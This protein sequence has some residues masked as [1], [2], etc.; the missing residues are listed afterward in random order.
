MHPALS[1]IFFTTLSGLGYGLLA[2]SGVAALVGTSPR[3][4]LCTLAL[5]VV[6]SI[7]G[8]LC[9]VGHLG[10]P[11]RAWRAFSQWRTS[12]LSR[13]GIVS[14]ATLLPALVLI[15]AL[16]ARFAAV[17]TGIA[18]GAMGIV[19][20][21]AALLLVLGAMATVYCTSMIYACLKPI[22]AWTH[23][24]VPAV[25]LLFELVT[26]GIAFL[27]LRAAFE[28]SLRR[29][30]QTHRILSTGDVREVQVSGDLAIAVTRLAVRIESRDDGA[31]MRSA[32]HSAA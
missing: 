31:A 13:E 28:D 21:I 6:A 8:L 14:L 2:W 3:A 4:L 7:T 30:L 27:A 25:Y 1:V 17:D 26:G 18:P 15:A 9:S 29:L 23:R 32:C 16:L 12:W 11:L 22:P 5:G 20:A 19:L 10:K 24:V